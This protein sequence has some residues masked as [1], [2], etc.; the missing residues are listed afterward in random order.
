MR[1]ERVG[2]TNRWTVLLDLAN[3]PRGARSAIPA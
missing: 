2:K 3:P 1:Y